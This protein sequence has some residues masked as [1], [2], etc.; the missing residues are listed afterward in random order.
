MR[1]IGLLDSVSPDDIKQRLKI[2]ATKSRIKQEKQE[3]PTVVDDVQF[4]SLGASSQLNYTTS[5]VR[6]TDNTGICV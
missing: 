1:S 6:T 4:S 5:S 2:K 3:T